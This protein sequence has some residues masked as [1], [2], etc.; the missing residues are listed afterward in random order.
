MPVRAGGGVR[1]ADGRAARALAARRPARSA[2][3]GRAGRALRGPSRRR[4]P[5]TRPRGAH[6]R[7]RASPSR[8]AA[9]CVKLA[10]S[11]FYAAGGGQVSDAGTIECADGDCRVRVDDVVR[12]AT[13]RRRRRGA[14]GRARPARGRARRRARRP[15]GAPRDAGQPHRDA[16]AARGAARA[17]RRPRAPGRLL[18]R[19]RQ[20]ALRLH[21]TPSAS[22]PRTPRTSRTRVNAWILRND[23]VRADHDDARRGQGARRDGAVRREVR[24]RRADG[25]D[26]RR[27][28]L[29]RAVRRHARALDRGDRRCSGSSR[30]G[31]S[32]ANVRRIEAVTGP[33]ARR[34]AARA[35]TTLLREA[36]ERAAH[37]ARARARGGRDAARPR[38]RPRRRR[39]RPRHGSVDVAALAARAVEVDGARGARPRRSTASTPRRCSTLAD[40]VK[41]QLGERRDRARQRAATASVHL[42][43][44]V[45]PALVE[46]GVK[47]GEIVKVA[48][49][50]AGG[51]G[52][53]TRHDGAG[54]R[55]RSGEA[56]RGDRGRP[57]GDRSRARASLRA[58]AG[59]GLRLR[60]LRLRA[61]R[62][63][64][65]AGDADRADRAPGD[66]SAASRASSSSSRE[67]EVER[68]VVGLPLRPARRRHRPDA[69]GARVRRAR[70]ASAG[71]R[72]GRALRR[73][74]HDRDRR[75]ARRGARRREDSRA[76]AVLLEDWLARHAGEVMG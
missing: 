26:R 38:R 42:V 30:E 69:R 75:S 66:A 65:H 1:R 62:P 47:A 74:L 59:P 67:R 61:E 55:P 20:A 72:A 17:A 49:Q 23:P 32:A 39:A 63:D 2:R 50:V 36:A 7:R 60:P 13:T 9:R 43:A 22:A 4:S 24:R 29:A 3:V 37:A 14:R 40:R 6:D 15:R 64:R 53:G 35:T 8:T 68:V 12:S 73:A 16:P 70:C 33:E 18:R 25:R 19:A 71:R 46:R 31:S 51:G 10:E 44:A 34:A 45:A 54:R 57:R 21:A 41:G 11:P 28:L 5:A 27:L 56:P 52:G 76:A 58:R 48:A